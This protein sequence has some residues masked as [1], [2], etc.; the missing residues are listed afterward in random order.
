MDFE[1]SK[2]FQIWLTLLSRVV[3]QFV[4]LSCLNNLALISLRKFIFIVIKLFFFKICTVS[5]ISNI[6]TAPEHSFVFGTLIITR[7]SLRGTALFSH[8]CKP[9]SE[10]SPDSH[11]SCSSRLMSTLQLWA[12]L[13]YSQYIIRVVMAGTSVYAWQCSLAFWLVERW[14]LKMSCDQTTMLARQR[15]DQMGS[16]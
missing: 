16:T 14:L 11:S 4:L 8:L 6:A 3:L 12:T 9:T 10:Y 5:H 13:L 15:K 7:F 2:I 1:N